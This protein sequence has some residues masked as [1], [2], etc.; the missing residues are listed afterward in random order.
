MQQ[1]MDMHSPGATRG[2]LRQSTLTEL[3]KREFY[4]MGCFEGVFVGVLNRDGDGDLFR[5]MGE[6]R[7]RIALLY[8]FRRRNNNVGDDKCVC[9]LIEESVIYG[10]LWIF[11]DE[12]FPKESIMFGHME[13]MTEIAGYRLLISG[14]SL[15]G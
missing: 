6:I 4:L 9:A 8:C 15:Q 7:T 11:K 2:F 5:S 1:E 14:K 13:E 12:T 10:R 3:M